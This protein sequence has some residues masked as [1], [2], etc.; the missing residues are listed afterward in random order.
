[1]SMLID[2]E[3]FR[4]TLLATRLRMMGFSEKEIEDIYN[5]FNSVCAS[6]YDA[7]RGCQCWNDE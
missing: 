2:L 4:K 3:E 5:A 7:D 6:C 1:M